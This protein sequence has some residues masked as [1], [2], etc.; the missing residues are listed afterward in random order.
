MLP[1]GIEEGATINLNLDRV[2]GTRLSAS[3]SPAGR[4]ARARGIFRLPTMSTETWAATALRYCKS[5]LV[6]G[7]GNTG[8]MDTPDG[9]HRRVHETGGLSAEYVMRG[10]SADGRW[11]RGVNA[12]GQ[13][14]WTFVPATQA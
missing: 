5:T 3:F 6:I 13:T 9:V 2:R 11:E 8:G 4:A 7:Q 14:A 10:R 1:L 12:G